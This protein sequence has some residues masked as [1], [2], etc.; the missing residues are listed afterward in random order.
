MAADVRLG[1]FTRPRSVPS[2]YFYDGRGSALFEAITRLPEYYQTRTE[3]ALLASLADDLIART[4]P[5]EL[6]ELGSG[7]GRKVGLLLDAMRR[8]GRPTRLTLFDINGT[9]ARQSAARL[10]SHHPA[11]AVRVVAGDFTEDLLALG[12]GG[13]RLAILFGGTIGNFH[14]DEV[15][16]FLRRLGARL[17]PGDHFLVGV[18][19]VKD[20][21]RLEAAYNDAAGVTAEF[22]RNILRHVNRA[23]GGDFDADAFEH[24]AFW[25]ARHE[26]IEMRLR[27]ARAMRVHVAAAHLDV[28]FR[29]GDEI[30]TEISCKYTRAAFERRLEASGFALDGWF[31][32]REALFAL[33]LLRRTA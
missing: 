32:D 26:W 10:A 3:E 2:K 24:V 27:A 15:A 6:V 18:D 17:A 8:A 9:V 12:N 25:D 4:R 21:A 30:R 11:V 5:T 31:T 14:P 22:N 20:R 33:A 1:L 7:A 28:S 13:G 19:T 23:L 16:G 29:A